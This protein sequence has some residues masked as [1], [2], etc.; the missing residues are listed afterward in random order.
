MSALLTL[1]LFWQVAFVP[2]CANSV[3]QCDLEAE[4]LPKDL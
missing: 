3:N 4:F 2:A 1:D